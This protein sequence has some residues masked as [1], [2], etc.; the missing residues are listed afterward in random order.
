MKY[1]DYFS[2]AWGRGKDIV[3]MDGIFWYFT[4]PWRN[5][6]FWGYRSLGRDGII[7]HGS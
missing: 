6:K 2:W 5:L 7:L 1:E 4:L 3:Q